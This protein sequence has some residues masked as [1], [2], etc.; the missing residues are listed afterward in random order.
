MPRQTEWLIIPFPL[1]DLLGR[2]WKSRSAKLVQRIF[3]TI[4]ALAK[5]PRAK[6]CRKLTT[7]KHLSRIRVGDYRVISAIDDDKEAID[8]VAVRHR[9][10]GLPIGATMVN[11]V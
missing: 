3:P 9:S 7:E 8:I 6:G 11:A 5:E 10:K 1:R 4:K 2:N